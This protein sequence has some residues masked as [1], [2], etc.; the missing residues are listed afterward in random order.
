M[1]PPTPVPAPQSAIS[2]TDDEEKFKV[3]S[4]LEIC[5]VLGALQKA[6]SLVT[7][8]FGSNNDF[9]LTCIVRVD[10]DENEVVLDC[11]ADAAANLRAL[12]AS[13]ITFVA[14]HEH[15]K[16]QFSADSL[17]K[18]RVDQRD[19]FGIPLPSAL[20]RLQRREYFRIVIPLSQPLKCAI[21]PQ[22]DAVNAPEKATVADISCG[23]VA[24][25]GF[26]TPA[27]VESGMCLHGCQIQL[28][29]AGVVTADLLIKSTF[30]V[31]LKNGSKHLHAG[32]E[33]INMPE[34]ARSNI[35]RYINAVERERKKRTGRR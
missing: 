25:V 5:S 18:L 23:G 20:L 4:R 29:D 13:G 26:S 3:Y 24:L 35:Q 8:Y 33:F 9:I 32:C 34:R 6:G 7:A 2:G 12:K 1:M 10:A 19:A 15:I 17:R 11:G 22:A 31:T 16:I 21:P 28:P 30:D 27:G 14:A